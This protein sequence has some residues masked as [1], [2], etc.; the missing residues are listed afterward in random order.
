M[1]EC[2]Y[3]IAVDDM[4]SHYAAHIES[5]EAGTTLGVN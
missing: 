5:I 2:V 3:M 1:F 4:C